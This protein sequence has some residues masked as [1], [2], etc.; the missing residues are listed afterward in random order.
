[1]RCRLRRFSSRDAVT[2]LYDGARRSGKDNHCGKATLLRL[3]CDCVLATRRLHRPHGRIISIGR[4]G[5]GALIL[6][7][8]VMTENIS[9]NL[10]KQPPGGTTARTIALRA[11]TACLLEVSAP[12]PGNVHRGADFEEMTYIDFVVSAV[13]I[14]PAIESAASGAGVGAAL[15][16]AVR[17]TREAVGVNT[18][19]GTLML[20]V[21][22]ARAARSEG[23]LRSAVGAVLGTMTREDAEPFYAAIRWARPGGMGTVAEHDIAGPA[24]QDLMTAMRAAADR[25]LIARQYAGGFAE[26]FDDALPWLESELAAG[27][28]LGDAIVRAFLRLLAKHPDSLIARKCGLDRA[29]D[30]S[31]RAAAVVASGTPGEDSYRRAVADFD[32][33]L[34]ADG[35]RRNPG[36][37]ADLIAATLFVAIEQ[38]IVRPPYR[39]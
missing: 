27:R 12:K 37:T 28:R 16:H 8:R 25:D 30:V 39:L 23:S 7:R 29:K 24:P 9:E 18:N 21:P 20:L 4:T 26:V 5:R 15:L 6:E 36:T 3:Y 31:V 32:F 38:G 34:R 33:W 13:A 10:P 17:A 35:R 11:A 1:M 19:L 22:L 2:E 14:G